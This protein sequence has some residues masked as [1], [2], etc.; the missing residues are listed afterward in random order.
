MKKIRLNFGFT[1]M[2]VLIVVSLIN[3]IAGIVMSQM[4]DAKILANDAHK[5]QEVMQVAN[6]MELYRSTFNTAPSADLVGKG[7]YNERSIEYETA[8]RE[9]VN[10][11]FYPEIPTSPSGSDYFYM[12][13]SDGLGVFLAI[14]LSQKELED[15]GN[16]CYF[17]NSEN[18]CGPDDNDDSENEYSRNLLLVEAES[19]NNNS[20]SPIKDNITG[21]A[22]GG[23]S[24]GNDNGG[25]Q[26]SVACASI[27]DDF[28]DVYELQGIIVPNTTQ[29]CASGYVGELD[30]Y[31]VDNTF[32]YSCVDDLLSP[33]E[34]ANCQV[35]FL[36]KQV[37]CADIEDYLYNER[38]LRTYI[39]EN[40]TTVCINGYL[41]PDNYT[42]VTDGDTLNYM[43]LS[44][45][46]SGLDEATPETAVWCNTK[47]NK[48]PSSGVPTLPR[49]EVF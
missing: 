27:P 37:A 19:C 6:A 14:L 43:C 46:I 31:V 25:E 9:L 1:L 35:S 17:S 49:R 7:F 8:M 5:K 36:Q 33:N 34:T 24:G 3:F 41:R 11:G 26:N 29:A 21:R 2:D 44:D 47:F 13:N 10:N 15:G 23:G 45:Q 18:Y 38:D 30:F 22:V 12:V 42:S 48:V 32:Y 16:G 28:Y 40:P 39:L 4:A 20:C